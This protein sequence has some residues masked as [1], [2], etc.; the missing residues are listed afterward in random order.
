MK[1]LNVEL[2]AQKNKIGKYGEF[3]QKEKMTNLVELKFKLYRGKSEWMN[4]NEK[5][6]EENKSSIEQ[7]EDIL[8]KKKEEI[9]KK[10]E[11]YMRKKK[12]KCK[13]GKKKLIGKIK[14]GR[15]W[16]CG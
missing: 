11:N 5:K 16:W 8:E 14:F 7:L 6:I 9:L 4:I 15:N 2:K 10:K 13:N 3:I 1:E 12:Q